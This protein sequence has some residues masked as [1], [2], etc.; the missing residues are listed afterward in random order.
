[1]NNLEAVEIGKKKDGHVSSG[2]GYF[3]EHQI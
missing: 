1:M 2:K 3:R